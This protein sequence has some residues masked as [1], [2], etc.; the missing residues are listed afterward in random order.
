M[1][2][3]CDIIYFANDW[4]ADNRTSSH[5]IATVL[6]QNNRLLYVECGG[7]RAP[8][9]SG[10]DVKRIF[11]KVSKFLSGRKRQDGFNDFSVISLFLLPFHSVP[12]IRR[13]NRW[14]TLLTL[15]YHLKRLHMPRPIAFFFFPHIGHLSGRLNEILSVYYCIDD[16]SSFPG[17][18]REE[19]KRM[20]RRL[21]EKADV[22]FVVSKSLLE[23]KKGF[24]R[25][26]FYSPHGV[27]LEHFRM[28]GDTDVPVEIRKRI[29]KEKVIL[30]WGLVADWTDFDL[31]EFLLQ[32]NP[33][34][35]FIFLGRVCVP[36]ERLKKYSNVD[37]FGPV[38]YRDLPAYAKCASA[39]IIPFLIN[40]W[41]SKINPIKLKE[42][43]ATGKPVVSTAIPEAVRSLPHI[44]VAETK[45]EFSRCLDQAVENDTPGAR[46]L[47]LQSIA[48]L[49][50]TNRVEEISSVIARQIADR[51]RETEWPNRR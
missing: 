13:L 9:A 42:Y 40:D 28:N 29:H 34:K 21:L 46:D 31:V 18:E 38:D 12:A 41:T 16:Y 6:G 2:K 20:D 37:F 19:I 5:Q 25:P 35:Q 23:D 26:V 3:D 43:L 48:D 50:W 14:I 1:L 47:R 22:T 49:T 8:A 27:D 44:A 36:V 32:N 51:N 24:S 45:E 11:A 39:L 17:V 15:K 4:N 10:R 30:Y 33:E 7:L